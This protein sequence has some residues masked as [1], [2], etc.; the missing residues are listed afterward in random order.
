LI[1]ADGPSQENRR[2]NDNSG[3]TATDVLEVGI[4]QGADIGGVLCVAHFS[5]HARKSDGPFRS[6]TR[7]YCLKKQVV[8][9]V[10]YFTTAPE[11]DIS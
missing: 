9:R 5:L 2:R 6:V 1:S 3:V 10:I 8:M 11:S 4:R 7:M